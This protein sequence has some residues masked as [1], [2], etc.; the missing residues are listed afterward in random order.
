MQLLNVTNLPIYL[1]YDKAAVP[2]GDPFSDLTATI[3]SPGV[4]TAPGYNPTNGDKVIVTFAA[5]GSLPG[6]ITNTANASPYT[7]GLTPGFPYTI[8]YV[9]G[10]VASTGAFNL[11]ATLGGAG[12]NTTTTGSL[13]TLHL[14][15][16]QVDGVTLPFK[17]GYTVLVENN[18][19]GTLV[20]QGAVDSGVLAPGQGYAP[21]AGPG[22]W[23]TLVSLVTGAQAL[24]QLSYD[25]IRVSTAG[26]LALQQ[27]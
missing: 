15:S 14:F 27:N 4:F 19:G 7:P 5:G 9:V 23:N 12:I 25:W 26:T 21:P 13:L 3:A 2:F 10:A 1:P 17:P 16:G 11:S 8:Y 6:G 18:S 22:T 20:L 24:V